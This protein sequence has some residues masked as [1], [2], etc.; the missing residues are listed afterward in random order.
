[1]AAAAA[2]WDARLQAIKR[3]AEAEHRKEHGK[4]SGTKDGS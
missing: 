2:R 4:T 3:L 1:M